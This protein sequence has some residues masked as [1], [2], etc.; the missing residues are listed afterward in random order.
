MRGAMRK[1]ATLVPAIALAVACGS[2]GS[3]SLP[4]QPTQATAVTSDVAAAYL[5]IIL[6]LMQR[7]SIKRLTID[8]T[9]FRSSVMAEARSAQTIAELN[10]AIRVAITLLGDGHS[11][12][13]GAGATSSIFVGTRSCR[14]SGA[15]QPSLPATIGYVK[16]TAFS[17][18]GDV[19]TA[20]A[21]QI[22]NTIAAADRDNLAGW[23]VDLRG[24]GGGNMWPMIAGVGPLLGEGPLGYFI[25]PT[26]VETLWEY[27]NGASLSGGFAVARVTTP[28]RLRTEQ[29]RVAV[30][31]DNGIASSGE[32]TLIAFRLR[33]NTRSFGEATCGLSTANSTFTLSDGGTLTLTTSV[34]ADRLKTP[35]GDSI[36]PDE[37]FANQAEAVQRAIAW[38]QTGT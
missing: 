26:G 1:L 34:M 12:Y 28:Y 22:Q 18:S 16:V 3:G 10:P 6:D 4:T 7:N 15:A 37:S 9:A 35:F 11:S 8:W 38:L 13:R 2:G 29:P 27:R 25:G 17:G 5:N 31:S 14:A 33:P 23:I 21:D 24:N 32:A 19:A 20:F 30:L 36:A